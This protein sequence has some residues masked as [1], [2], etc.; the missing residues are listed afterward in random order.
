MK[1]IYVSLSN[2]PYLVIL[3]F[4]EQNKTWISYHESIQFALCN[5]HVINLYL[6]TESCRKESPAQECILVPLLYPEQIKTRQREV[7]NIERKTLTVI[8]CI[9]G[10]VLN[11]GK[12]RASK[13]IIFSHK[14][15]KMTILTD[16]HPLHHPNHVRKHIA[17][18]GNSY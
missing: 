6:R 8:L 1:P 5:P 14:L 9:P 15:K 11:V 13:K 4:D 10:C 18:V 16:L 2:F 7:G 17:E 12:D 3:F